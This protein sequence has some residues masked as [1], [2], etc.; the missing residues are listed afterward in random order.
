MASLIGSRTPGG[1]DQVARRQPPQAEGRLIGFQAQPLDTSAAERAN[2]LANTFSRF[3][4]KAG[5]FASNLAAQ[6]GAEQGLAVPG[7]AEA[8]K[9]KA[10]LAALTPYGQAYNQAVLAGHE[11]AVGTDI[12][13]NMARIAD[14]NR[15]DSAAFDAAV[16]G[17]SKGLLKGVDP[18]LRARAEQAVT[19]RAMS[20]RQQIVNGERQ[21]A[22]ETA[23]GQ[24][25]D[26]LLSL[27]SEEL[28]ARRDGDFA[29]AEGLRVQQS[30]L[31]AK[32]VRGDANPDG[33]LAPEFVA[34]LRAGQEDDAA[35]ETIVGQGERMVRTQGPDAAE[36]WLAGLHKKGTTALGV[37]PDTLDKADSRVSS[38][39]GEA[40]AEQR[41]RL[42]ELQD[43]LRA[44]MED[45][46]A[47]MAD[48]V[49]PT[50]PVSHGEVA[51]AFGEHADKVWGEYQS[52]T[53]LASD[54]HALQNASPDEQAAIIEKA[55]PVAGAGYA[56]QRERQ[57]MLMTQAGRIEKAREEDPAA[58][59]S[60]SPLV[61]R[62]SQSG[63]S[64][65]VI[66]ARMAE[67]QRIGVRDP[68]PLTKAEVE[69][70]AATAGDPQI[71]PLKFFANVD[72]TY[73]RNARQ[74][75][76][77][78]QAKLPPAYLA[79][80]TG[81]M[82]HAAAVRLAGLANVDD[83]VQ[84]AA[85]PGTTSTRDLNAAIST[86]LA[87]LKA[88][89]AGRPGTEKTI[90][91]LTVGVRK[92]ALDN[93]RRGDDLGSAARKAVAD[94]AGSYTY[95]ERNNQTVRIPKAV[96]AGA[97]MSGAD[98][99]LD[100]LAPKDV[101]PP[102]NDLLPDYTSPASTGGELLP[103]GRHGPRQY[104]PQSLRTASTDTVAGVQ[105]AAYVDRLKYEGQWVT[106]ADES[107]VELW[108]DGLPVLGADGT[109]VGYSWGALA[110]TAHADAL[111]RQAKFKAA[112]FRSGHVR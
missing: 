60:Q 84:L 61:K 52:K 92:L 47:M 108:L 6:R 48:G 25:T 16:G 103:G 43:S 111:E 4:R 69:S 3:T 33:I 30:D 11:A 49:D 7:S 50:R 95:A 1:S 75:R 51:A 45:T 57:A 72:Q 96:D 107:G 22:L 71:D 80:S 66:S 62:A 54:F 39:I 2:A 59:V 112:S 102:T 110:S 78:L 98:L 97:V 37:N 13:S 12:A 85:I 104:V 36:K 24:V 29:L 82:P 10:G 23:S 9:Q 64:Q 86:S 20:A 19:V 5:E 70:L 55:A 81:N 53:R 41:A 99:L 87:D 100:R 56:D 26:N 101:R 94:V 67:Q 44:R 79:L 91:D 68:R 21:R 46:V 93:M 35:F 38:L 32:N 76:E 90:A 74:V 58:A 28:R 17:Y 34:K 18:A 83:K 14:A 106:N 65:E 42:G 88:S 31:I 105:A 15:N 63:S 27:R 73:G 89:L 109:Q 40:R 77:Q 8:P